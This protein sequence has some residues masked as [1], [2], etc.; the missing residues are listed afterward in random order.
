MQLHDARQGE[1]LRQ[2]DAGASVHGQCSRDEYAGAL[3]GISGK[4][5]LQGIKKR[6]IEKGRS[7]R[8]RHDLMVLTGGASFFI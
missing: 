8:S 7:A 1:T 5:R 6:Q 2:R 3:S 4:M